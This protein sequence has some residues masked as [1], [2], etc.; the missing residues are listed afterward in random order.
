MTSQSRNEIWAVRAEILSIHCFKGVDLQ[1][2]VRWS[3]GA[4]WS[5]GAVW[6]PNWAQVNQTQVIY[7][8]GQK[9]ASTGG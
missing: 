8:L 7:T 1:V 9:D 6:D 2:Q 4:S 5:A 3:A